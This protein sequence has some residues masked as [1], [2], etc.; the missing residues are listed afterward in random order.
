MDKEAF[1][2]LCHLMKTVKG[3]KDTSNIDVEEMVAI[4]LYIIAHHTKNRVIK[5]QIARSSETVSR[6]FH[7]VL[8]AVLPLHSLLC[9][10]LVPIA[11]SCTYSRRRSEMRV[12][13]FEVEVDDNP[14]TRHPMENDEEEDLIQTCETSNA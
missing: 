10:K 2:K 6:T 13:P 3:L 14:S 4:F 1:A 5:W 8:K 11:D 7:V 12:D 9:Q